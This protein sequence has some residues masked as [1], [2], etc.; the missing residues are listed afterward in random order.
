MLD[1]LKSIQMPSG[2]YHGGHRHSP[3]LVPVVFD[4][5]QILFGLAAGV[6]E[7]GEHYASPLRQAADWLVNSQDDDGVWRIPNPF[8]VPG[9]HLWETHVAWGLLEAA[10]V[11]GSEVYATA[12]MKN[13]RWAASQ[14]HANGWYPNCGLGRRDFEAPLTHCIGYTLRGILEGYRFSHEASLLDAGITTAD[15]LLRVQQENG[16]IPGQL[17][18]NWHPTVNWVCLTGCVQI[19]LCWFLLFRETGRQDYLNAARKA[20]AFVRRTMLFDAPPSVRGA[21]KGS[22]PISGNYCSY[23]YINWACKFMIDANTLEIALREDPT[24]FSS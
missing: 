16:S 6:R 23:Q 1:W 4:T 20:N 24:P 9:D 17:D 13:I 11:T 10:K 15:A 8:A 21:V 5:G 22:Y 12:G 19:A 14:Q 3:N 7:F 18:K 2:A